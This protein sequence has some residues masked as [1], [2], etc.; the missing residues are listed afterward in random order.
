MKYRGFSCLISFA[1]VFIM[2]VSICHA[3]DDGD[4]P[5][6]KYHHDKSDR[7][8]PDHTC[9][10]SVGG[11]GAW[12][13]FGNANENFD[14]G[15]GI[16]ASGGFALTPKRKVRL[17]FVGT[18]LYAK[19]G[20]TNDALKSSQNIDTTPFAKDATDAEGRFLAV[21]FDPT[22]RFAVKGNHRL[23]I[24]GLGGFGWLRRDIN[25]SQQNQGTLVNPSNSTLGNVVSSSGI[26]DF[27]T[28][29]N[30]APTWLHGVMIYVEGRFYHGAAIN[31]KTKLVPF[32]VGIRW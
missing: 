21:T 23:D 10:V 1:I 19:L 28:G 3:R 27:G 26:Y 13:P 8:H 11:I 2:L 22:L 18:Y 15:G 31:N 25:F 17:F 20:V 29:V 6:S 5:E 24:Y 4:Y 9:T 7:D 14:W 30:Y 12:R 32:S 16:Q